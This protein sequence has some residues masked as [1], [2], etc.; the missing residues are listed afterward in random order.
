MLA[1]DRQLRVWTTS[2]H[3][4]R[5]WPPCPSWQNDVLDAAALSGNKVSEGDTPSLPVRTG[6]TVWEKEG[7]EREA[8]ERARTEK[9]P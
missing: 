5:L 8:A 7:N 1:A 9:R 2:T 6:Y 3:G 4:K